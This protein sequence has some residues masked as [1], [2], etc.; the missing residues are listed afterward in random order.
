MAAIEEGTGTAHGVVL[1]DR[2]EELEWFRDVVLDLDREPSGIASA[3][4]DAAAF[5]VYD[6]HVSKRVSQRLV[7]RTGVESVAYVP[8]LA[9]QQVV[10]RAGDDVTL[11][12]GAGSDGALV[13][14]AVEEKH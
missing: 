14:C 13:V 11:F 7:E 10:A 8:I 1:L 6:A 2:G 5:A 9:G 4:H 3:Y 12:G